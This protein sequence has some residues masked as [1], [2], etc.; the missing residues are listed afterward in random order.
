[1][2]ID[3]AI[4]LGLLAVTLVLFALEWLSVDVVTL[5]LLAALIV[6]GL[7]TP[8]DAFSGFANEIIVIL[9]SIFVISGALVKTGVMEW[10]GT[11]LHRLGG[12]SE[13][14]ILGVLMGLSASGSAFL[15][16]TN[17]TAILMPAVA[18][19]SR[20]SRISPSRLL[21]PLAYASILGGACT[22][23]GTSTNMAASGLLAKL[24]LPPFSMFE[25]TAVG[26]VM[27]VAGI[28]YMS[29][30]GI[31][32]LPR[33]PVANLSEE[34][35]IQQYLA[36]IV[37]P[38]G[39]DLIGQSLRQA[40]L[41]DRGLFILRIQRGSHRI[42]PQAG[43][44]LIAGDVLTVQ[45]TREGLLKAKEDPD[46]QLAADA[47]LGDQDLRT[48]D[49]GIAEAVVMP[50]SNLVSRTLEEIGFYRRF[51]AAVLAI[52]RRGHA[53]PTRITRLPLRPGDVLLL[54]APREQLTRLAGNPDLWGVT[55]I[56]H[57]PGRRKKGTAVLMTLLAAVAL[58]SLGL[59]PLSVALLLA[60]LVVVLTRCITMEE[61]Y[62]FI[63]W[64]LIVLIGGMTSVGLAMETTRAADVLA[65]LIVSW[66]LPLGIYAVL[67]MFVVLTILLTQPMSNAAAALVVLPVA[68][69]TAASIGVN[70]RTLAVLVT[71]AASLSFL[72]PFEPAC[73]L[74]YGPGRYRFVDFIRS[75]LPLTA[76]V[77]AILL[78][79]VPILWPL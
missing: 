7:L 76:V 11:A 16:N 45:A 62:R 63:E 28:L 73:L 71:L 66:T 39:S 58:G 75:G 38:E 35:Q 65:D 44:E 10:L 24:G 59:L 50:Q 22:L 47:K 4:L 74:I 54:Q 13:K 78:V 21:M 19:L 5:A 61:A 55:E 42:F 37:V 46:L 9:S 2:T 68:L 64:R 77:V 51:G 30:L 26:V 69:S 36:Q 15:S 57:L 31:R 32:R 41:P 53:Y 56:E 33:E 52:Y 8:A 48:D 6:L 14:R 60:A 29:I 20:R 34:Y 49:V 43:T 23:I 25:F 70:P 72:T 67:A 18:D 12:G 27:A 1:M 79:L 3:I 40:S 17:T